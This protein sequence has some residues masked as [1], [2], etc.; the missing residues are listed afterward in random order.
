MAMDFADWNI[1]ERC[2]GNEVHLQKPLS[3]CRYKSLAVEVSTA[4]GTV[5]IE[6]TRDSD[7]TLTAEVFGRE[8]GLA[9]KHVQKLESAIRALQRE[10]FR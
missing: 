9:P 6:V 4:L 1:A 7:P 5:T 3:P 8:R 10:H 2:G